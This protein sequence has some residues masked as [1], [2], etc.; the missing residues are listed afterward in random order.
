MINVSKKQTWLN[1]YVQPV[2]HCY[3]PRLW[4]EQSEY[5]RAS[6]NQVMSLYNPSTVVG[7]ELRSTISR[8]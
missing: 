6:I 5:E 3:T 8:I 2:F 7:N 1:G 4:R